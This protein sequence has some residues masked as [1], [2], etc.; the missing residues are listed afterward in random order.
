MLSDRG[1][2]VGVTER[3]VAIQKL[4]ALLAAGLFAWLVMAGSQAGAFQLVTSEEAALPARSI[5]LLELRGSP[6]RRPIVVVVSPAP[7]AG[8]VHSPL[9]LRLEFRAFG[10]SEIDPDSVVV[11]YLK[12]PAIDI[13]QRI[14]PFISASGIIITQAGIPPGKHEFWVQLKDKDGRLGGGEVSFQV[15]K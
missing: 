9:D 2:G 13:T 7:G 10:G 8:L 4:S 5:P 15:T 6:T 14:T 11:T 3:L 1:R 12:D